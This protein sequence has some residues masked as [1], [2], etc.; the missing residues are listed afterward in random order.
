MT[1]LTYQTACSK[2]S[3]AE[4]LCCAT[5]LQNLSINSNK[6]VSKPQERVPGSYH[7]QSLVALSEYLL[8]AVLSFEMLEKV[9]V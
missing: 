8:L 1:Y 5:V 2:P 6:N 3:V 4:F 7:I 9:L